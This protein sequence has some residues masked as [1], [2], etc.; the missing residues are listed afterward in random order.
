MQ[1][2]VPNSKGG[3]HPDTKPFDDSKMLPGVSQKIVA[4]KLW[5]DNALVGGI[6]VTYLVNGAPSKAPAHVGSQSWGMPTQELYLDAD[7]SIIEISGWHGAIMNKVVFKTNK[8]KLLQGGGHGPQMFTLPIAP[9]QQAIVIQ[10]GSN[11]HIHNIGCQVGPLFGG[12]M[13]MGGGFSGQPAGVMAAPTGG[14]GQQPAG[15]G[16]QQGGFGGP[17]PGGFGSMPPAGGIGGQQGQIQYSQE[18]AS[19][20][21]PDSRHFDTLT[22]AARN[23][24]LHKVTIFHNGQLVYGLALAWTL[25]DGQKSK[26]GYI[27]RLKELKG[28]HVKKE[29]LKL[30]PG[31]QV[32]EVSGRHGELIDA[33]IIRTNAGRVIQ[34]GG[35]GGGQFPNL[36]PAGKQLAG[37]YGHV[38]GTIHKIGIFYK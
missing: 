12:G 26:S 29:S 3:F 1:Q 21:Y 11:G 15:F 35:M 37:F 10:G 36:L 27:G 38:G 9:G 20:L 13:S 5:A 2:Q 24:V 22:D 6:E 25:P 23:G 31:E 28:H 4:I 33:I 14:F 7:E 8:G 17:Q 34:A 32:I 16:M 30:N 19:K 18:T